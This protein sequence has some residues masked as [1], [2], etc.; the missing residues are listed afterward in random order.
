[1][2]EPVLVHKEKEANPFPLLKNKVIAVRVVHYS[3]VDVITIFK[4]IEK[5]AN[6]RM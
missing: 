2:G 3:K 4:I 1:M 6:G 5:F